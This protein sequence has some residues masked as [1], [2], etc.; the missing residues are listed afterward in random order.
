MANFRRKL[1]SANALFVFEAAGRCGSLTKAAAELYVSQP[2]VSRM[3]A[4]M[5]ERMGV[6]LY[7]RVRGGIELT[8]DGRLLHRAI[9]E[10]FN[11][12]E[13]SISEIEARATG[14]ETITLS[15][16]TAFTTHW[17]MPRMEKLRRDF[18]GVDLRFQLISGKVGGPMHDVDL[19]V[20]FFTAGET[21]QNGALL[22]PEIILPISTPAYR[23]DSTHG[24]D[25]IINLTDSFRDWPNLFPGLR[26][27]DLDLYSLNFS[28]YSIVIQT[29][30]LGQGIAP[31]WLNVVSHWMRLGTLV[32]AIR[33][34]HVTERHCYLVQQATA[35]PRPTVARLRDWI[36]E[37]TFQDIAE[38]DRMYPEMELLTLARGGHRRGRG[39]VSE[40]PV[41]QGKSV[42]GV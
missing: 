25:I 32:P 23:D 37:E 38:I 6:P 16:S 4:R 22:M 19:G 34:A 33:Q 8:D 20:R 39:V 31:G 24:S 27:R 42:G 15:V 41:D 13:A 10:G 14:M 7:K 1:P 11:G 9:T 12:I 29:A 28:D 35:T 30:M 26:K 17:M 40:L 21:P 5:E 2:A 18:P 3:M 36:V